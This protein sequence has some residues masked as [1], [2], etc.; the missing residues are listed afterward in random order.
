LF[1]FFHDIA[2]HS[3]KRG[4]ELNHQHLSSAFSRNNIYK[5]MRTLST[6]VKAI[7]L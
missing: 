7:R 3:G 2:V 5:R 4:N 6:K 1:K